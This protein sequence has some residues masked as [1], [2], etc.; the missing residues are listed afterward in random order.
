MLWAK[1]VGWFVGGGFNSLAGELRQAQKDRLEAANDAERLRAEERMDLALRRVE[2]QT[3][4]AGTFTAKTARFLF[5]L[6]FIIYVNKIVLWD[7]V[8]GLG[9]TDTL[10][11]FLEGIAWTVIGFYFLDNTLRLARR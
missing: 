11:P 7:K 4:G 8:L 10:S 2:A 3:R 6:P 9:A 5:A 1:L